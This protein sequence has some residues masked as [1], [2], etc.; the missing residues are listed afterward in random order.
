MLS[1]SDLWVYN[2]AG[3]ATQVDP[4]NS[5]VHICRRGDTSGTQFGAN[6]HFFGSG[7]SKGSG[8]G[9]VATPDNLGTQANGEVWTGSAAQ[10]ADFVFAG[11][12]TGD[13]RSCAS[14]TTIAPGDAVAY[15][16]GYTS[17]DQAIVSGT[18]YRFIAVNGVAPTIWNIQRGAYDW[19]T[20]DTFNSNSTSLARNGSTNAAA[21]FNAIN[22]NLSNV[23]GLAGLNAS[24]Q[25]SAAPGDTTGAADTGLVTLGNGVLFGTNNAGGPT[26]AN[27]WPAAIRG[28][29]T[30]GQ[31][32][33]SPVSLT[34]PSSPVNNCNGAFQAD[35][36]G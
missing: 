5:L 17:T 11:S 15:R 18:G 7:C 6:I 30:A 14:A 28:I 36:T 12:G 23:N 21:I 20:E 34:Y 1:L 16:I 10:L 13:V 26:P 33:N 35:P 8:V 32:P 31:G 27:G 4:T 19:L 2:S 22:A 29:N 25:N 9:S 3:A 24:S